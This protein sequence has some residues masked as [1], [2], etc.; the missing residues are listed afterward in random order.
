MAGSYLKGSIGY[1]LELAKRDGFD[2]LGDW[3]RWRIKTGRMPN[4]TNINREYREK[5]A[6]NNGFENFNEYQMEVKKNGPL[7]RSGNFEGRICIICGSDKTRIKGGGKPHWNTYR[8]EDG[9]WDRKSYV[10][11]SCSGKYDDNSRDNLIKLMRQSR[12][13]SL[14]RWSETGIATI[15]QW[16]GANALKL[17][18]LNIDNNNFKELVDLSRHPEHGMLDVKTRSLRENKWIIY[19]G[20]EHNFDKCVIICMDNNEPWRDV[21]RTYIVPDSEL[22]GET[23]VTIC[24]DW[25]SVSRRGGAKFEWIEEYRVCEKSYNDI[26][27]S[28]KIPE[29]FSPFDLWKG[30]YDS[31]T[32]D[33]KEVM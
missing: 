11:D 28:V 7:V 3:N 1:Y 2:N 29:F 26:Y 8:D 16:I 5:V 15:G 22:Y 17:R 12:T 32:S 20:M 21:K 25:S 19:I 23:V 14:S 31:N 27:H 24:E 6:N 10:C 9:K 4:I 33:L 30:K 13:G 18:D